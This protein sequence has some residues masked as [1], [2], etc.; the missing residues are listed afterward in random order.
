[1][2]SRLGRQSHYR[3]R[4][5][6]LH[7]DWRESQDIYVSLV[8]RLVG[9]TTTLLDVGCGHGDFMQAVY[10]KTPATYGVD[11]D[12]R[13]LD[14]N[15]VIQNTVC[16]TAEHLPFP[17]AF[18]D[19]V[20][21]AWTVEHL[22]DPASAFTEIH[23]VVKP[24]GH[25]VFLTPNTW[26]YNVWIIRLI[27][28]RLHRFFTQRLYGRGEGDTFPT[29]Y[30]MNSPRKVRE[31]LGGIGFREVRLILNSDPSYISFN[32]A[33]FRVACLIEAALDRWFETGKVHLIGVYR[34]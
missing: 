29:R 2:A 13:A 6:E 23:R 24:D 1:M 5:R 33:L 20:V 7:P 17:N 18:F 27:P 25:L 4:Y 10:Q 30:R 28:N 9:E 3:E 22:D 11:P 16:G 34:K 32:D 26:N 15:V 14:K 19:V 12:Q 8:D 31:T 21:S